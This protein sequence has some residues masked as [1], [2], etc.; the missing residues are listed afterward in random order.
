[1]NKKK[2]NQ[3]KSYLNKI[4]ILDSNCDFTF[5]S[6]LH[7]PKP[8]IDTINMKEFFDTSLIKYLLINIKN[9]FILILHIFLKL[10]NNGL[11]YNYLKKTYDNVFV[12]HLNDSSQLNDLYR[13]NH[14]GDLLKVYSK[15]SNVLK[16][17]IDHRKFKNL[18]DE[19][20]EDIVIINSKINFLRYLNIILILI[21]RLKKIKIFF[22]KYNF[23]N[24]NF[25]RYIKNS[26]FD[27]SS[28]LNYNFYNEIKKI[29]KSFEPN[30]IFFTFEGHSYERLIILAA[31]SSNK[32]VK[33]FAYPHGCI[34]KFQNS[35]FLKLNHK[36]MPDYILCPGNIT[37][38]YFSKKSF[39][40][41]L[42]IGSPRFFNNKIKRQ[43]LNLKNIL[44]IP[45]GSIS[46]TTQLF[47]LSIFLA[48]KYKNL[49]FFFKFHPHFDDI[50]KFI[51][52]QR[53]KNLI[54]HMNKNFSFYSKTCHVVIFKGSAAILEYVLSG[55][56]PKYY[57]SPFFPSKNILFEFEES[58]KFEKND[59][60][61]LRYEEVLFSKIQSFC[62]NYYV[63]QDIN[64]H[65]LNLF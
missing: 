33:T 5:I 15:Q 41:L 7:L 61:L 10:R 63:K 37:F 23:E 8:G 39:K 27:R 31:N 62:K 65:K 21:K 58:I 55:L 32:K 17:F 14:F 59:N 46:E 45:D 43:V 44:I 1:M 2:Y 25:N 53:P 30:N 47:E 26:I 54:I 3:L 35:M 34:T 20:H 64:F 4:L 12:C 28:V 52:F 56:V 38:Q 22:K 9:S 48:K 11:K 16:I 60:F 13:N 19:E 18:I 24:I 6:N 42:I 29:I 50:D 40:N 51:N 57:A 36:V 49:K